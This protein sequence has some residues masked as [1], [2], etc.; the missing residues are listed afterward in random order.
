MIN[1]LSICADAQLIAQSYTLLA[2]LKLY[3]K[4]GGH[5]KAPCQGMAKSPKD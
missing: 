2:P 4:R 3:K 5:L 1:R